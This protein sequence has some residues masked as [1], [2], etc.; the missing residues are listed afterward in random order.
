MKILILGGSGQ[1]GTE[2]LSL[3]KGSNFEF[4]A[5]SSKDL[6]ITNL[7]KIKSFIKNNKPDLVINFSAYTN[8]D[9]AENETKEALKL[10]YLSLRGLIVALNLNTIPL[11]HI[12]TDYVF[13]KYGKGP[14][15]VKDRTGAINK[16]GYS[17][18]L[19]ENEIINF[20][21]KAIIIRTASL[22]GEFGN[23]FLK[24]FVNIL[25]SKKEINVISD[26]AVSLTWSFDLSMAIIKLLNLISLPNNWLKRDGV[27]IIH[28]V[29][30]GYSSWFEA[31]EVIA[32]VINN[33]IPN[34]FPVKVNPILSKDWPSKVKRPSDSR[35]LS[36]GSIDDLGVISMPEWKKSLKACTIS[37]LERKAND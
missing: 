9:E 36:D 24:T 29:N 28:L 15:K 8:V 19:G 13:G 34:D 33:M 5:P 27:D 25:H 16:Y 2:F 4:L 21:K 10:N 14:Y 6:D 35:L 12:S 18:L 30:T 17:K 32:D 11:I 1:L 20:S 26:Q 7:K 3:K 37:Y 23:N 31:S 22:Y